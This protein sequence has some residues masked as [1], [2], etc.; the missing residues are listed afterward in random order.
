MMAKDP[1][2]LFY[3]NDYIGGTMG[4][5]FEEKGAYMEV[6]MMQFNRGHMEG[7]MVGQVIGQLW[8]KIKDKFIQDENGL[9]FN[10]RLEQEQSK[11]K[12]FTASRKNNLSGVNQYT[13][14]EEKST[15]KE[16][17]MAGHMSNHMEN[18]NEN[19]NISNKKA[20][21]L[22]SFQTFWK[23]YDKKVG[24]VT[25]FRRWNNLKKEDQE[26]IMT[27]LPAYIDSTPDKMFRMNPQT[28]LNQ[29]AWNDEIIDRSA[30]TGGGMPNSYDPQYERKLSPQETIN[31]HKHL[32][33][34]GFVKS[35]SGT[36]G[37]SWKRQ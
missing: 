27:N 7:H 25:C 18:E 6:L 2:F 9:W 1:A 32:V 12:K 8:D 22:E 10:E 3:P 36:G 29:E 16:G 17:H 20:L 15:K 37:T 33:S 31:Y 26:Q 30:A 23:L 24:K 35:Y 21:E 28:Y 11:R 19:E 4:M 14:K 34:L 5:T 13:E